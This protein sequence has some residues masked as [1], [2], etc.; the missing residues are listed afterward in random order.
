M[1]TLSHLSWSLELF[2][3]MRTSSPMVVGGL[4]N[5]EESGPW[6]RFVITQ[7]LPSG[8]SV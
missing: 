2:R 7:L 1:M 6:A 4:G 5:G 3:L 8:S